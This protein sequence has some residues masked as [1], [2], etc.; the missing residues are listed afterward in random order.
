[1]KTQLHIYDFDATL[2]MSPMHPDDWEGHIGHWYDT[3][4]SLSA[5]CVIDPPNDLWI[6]STVS[7]AHSSIADPSVYAILMTGRTRKS[8]LVGRITDLLAMGGLTF[9]E[10]LL[11][12]TGDVRTQPWKS[13]M[14]EKLAAKLS[15]L[16]EV[17]IWE[18]RADH[19]QAFIKLVESMGL[20]AVPHFVN[21]VLNAPCDLGNTQLDTDPNAVMDLPSLSKQNESLVRRYIKLC[22]E[23]TVRSQ[24]DKRVLYHINRHRPAKPQPKMSYWQQW[25]SNKI[26]RFGDEGDFVNIPGTDNWKRWWLDS[27]VK[28]GV[29]LTPNPL[30]IAMNHGRSGHVYAYKVPE[31][32]IDKSGGMH[33][34]DTGSEVLIPEDVWNEAG[35]EIEFMGKSMEQEELWD[36]MTGEMYGRGH[37]RPAIRPSWMSDE[38]LK[39]WQVDQDKFNLTGLRSTKYPEDVI[40]LLTPEERRKAIEAIEA[41]NKNDPTTIEKGPRDKK[42]IVVPGTAPGIDKK[43]QELLALLNKHL[44]ED[45]LRGYVRA[46]LVEKSLTGRK[47]EKVAA[48]IADEVVEYLLDEDLR[49]AFATQGTL[50]FQ[51]EVELPEAVLWLRNVYVKMEPSDIFNSDASYEFD[52]DA[53]DEQREESDIRINLQIPTDYSDEELEKLKVEIEADLRHELEH[54]GQSTDV[55]MD[56]QRNVPDSEIWKSLE[57]ANYYYTSEAEVP[58]YVSSLVLKSKRHGSHATDEIDEDLNNIYATG[59][60]KG[61][62]EEEL[63]SLMTKIRDV[64]QYYLMSRWPEQEWPIEFRPEVELS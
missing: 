18:D 27:P 8:E 52:L 30:D 62:S 31:W 10:V 43:N 53:T 40:K 19:L 48:L 42:G 15:D 45:I 59:L 13:S 14:I 25:D 35:K 16:Q 38:E 64:W 6:G 26:D 9:E 46:L 50:G 60:N 28:S 24:K 21:V 44:N 12:P 2:F 36:K 11:K 55:L 5:P 34:Y 63:G 29:F 33:R 20:V 57:R 58:S 1:M 22:L 41:K 32:V 54:S 56:V 3:L 17:H 39:K 61:Y 7:S 37:H 51:V 47:L 4:Q 49:G 23:K